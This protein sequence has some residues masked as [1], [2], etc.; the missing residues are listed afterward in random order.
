MNAKVI[1]IGAAGNKAAINLI[2]K[3]IVMRTD[4]LLLN[5]TLKDIPKAYLDIAHRFN[6]EVEGCGKQRE[7]AKEITLESIKD[8]SLVLDSFL[9]PQDDTV[10]LVNSS[11]GGTGCGASIIIAKYFK[12]VLKINVHTFVFT[13]FEDDG[14]GLQNTIE[15]FQEISDE[16]TVEAISNKKFL[17][18]T[19]TRQKAEQLANDEFAMRIRILLGQPLV[20]SDQNIDTMDLYKLST[21]PGY[22]IIDYTPLENIKN[23]EAYNKSIIHMLDECKAL[24]ISKPSCNKLGVIFNVSDKIRDYVDFSSEIIK[25]RLGYPYEYFHQV[26]FEGDKDYVAFIA[27]GMNMPLDEVKAIYDSYVKSSNKVNKDKDDFFSVISELKGFSED[28]K[29]DVAPRTIQAPTND[30]KKAFFNEFGLEAPLDPK[31]KNVK[32]SNTASNEDLKNNY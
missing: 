32:P 23:I 16:Y 3:N 19:T 5:S 21:N 29:F 28:G 26:Q 17:K 7:L 10:I 4:V 24:D 6:E 8:G 12:Q 2:E 15:Y 31:F 30:S 11:E 27:S 22:M 20:D 25:D 18:E 1:G 9:D 14:R 13:G